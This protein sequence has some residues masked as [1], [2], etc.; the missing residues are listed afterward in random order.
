MTVSE[1]N[2]QSS[3]GKVRIPRLLSGFIK[4]AIAQKPSN[5]KLAIAIFDPMEI[6]EFC[7][8]WVP[9]ICPDVLPPS[10]EDTRRPYG[11]LAASKKIIVALTQ[12][13]DSTVENWIYGYRPAPH[14]LKMYLRTI[15][16]IWQ[17]QGFFNFPIDF[18]KN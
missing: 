4:N 13:S 11:Y 12:S 17:M 16:I 14:T 15:H 1:R 7:I 10:P 3:E 2:L 6:E 5:R 8:I 18:P 9:V